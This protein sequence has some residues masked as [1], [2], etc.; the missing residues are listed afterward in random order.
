MEKV[1]KTIGY[2]RVSTEKQDTEKNKADVLLFANEKQ[3]G[4]VE[5]IEETVTGAKSWQ[6]R[7]LK[8]VIDSLK[9]GDRLITPELSRLGRNMYD[10]IS[11]IAALKEK[12]VN[13]YAIKGNWELNGSIQ[14]KILAMVLSMAAEIERELITERSKEGIRRARLMG[15]KFGRPKGKGKS[16]LDK[17]SDEI[18]ALLSNGSTKIFIANKYGCT[19]ASLI[20]WLKKNGYGGKFLKK[21]QA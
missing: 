4:N 9:E 21:Q 15:V 10:V 12:G 7:K 5:F 17:H 14:S 1:Q 13:V 3:F 6:D 20:N 18:I 16:K 19:V 2:L 11:V 8:E